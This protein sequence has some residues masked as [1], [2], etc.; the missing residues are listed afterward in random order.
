M[1]MLLV[2]G[3]AVF[4]GTVGA[5]IFRWL[6]IPQ[7]VGYI[8][9]GVAVGRTGLNIIDESLL[10][11]LDP[12]NFFA[13]GV[14]GFMIGGELRGDVFRKYGRQFL[15]ILVGE[16]IGAFVVVGLLVGGG[17]YLLRGDLN[18]AVAL[19]L[20]FGAISAATAPAAT[21][22]VLWEYKTR[23]P[24][25]RTVFAIV[26]MDD[27]LALVLYSVAASVAANLVGHGSGGFLTTIGRA[28]YELVG[29]AGLGVVAGLGLNLVLRRA[30][31]H[32]GV[33]AFIIGAVALV[34]GVGVLI[35]VD[36]ILASMALGMV[37]VNLAPRRSDRAFKIVERFAPPL[38]VL[39]FVIV[40]AHLHLQGMPGWMWVLAVPYVVG[41]TAGKIVGSN[42][43]GR[44]GKAGQPVCKYLGLCLFCQ[45][46][47]A[48]RL[49]IMA[50]KRFPGDMSDIGVAIIT[51]IA[52][53]TLVVE[54]LG[55]PCVKYAVK[56]AGEVGLN[57]TEEDLMQSYTV[58][59][60][61]DRSAPT[62]AESTS[63]AEIMR[64]IVETDATAYPVT[65]T[66]GG[67]TGVITF[68]ELKRSFGAE[69]LTLWLVAYDVMQPVPDRVTEDTP[70]VEAMTRMR[71]QDLEYLPVVVSGDDGERLVGMLE[72]RAVNRKVGQEI[73]RRRQQAGS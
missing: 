56:A 72:Q 43:G 44:L 14:I 48:V 25:T 38:Y 20:L 2:I 9:I 61:T 73:L 50:S 46:G 52:V 59:E 70:L 66:D 18:T 30:R 22:N 4:L 36:T 58:G 11:S 15:C 7:V 6:H 29:G 47:V 45:G 49:P 51:L 63:L 40:G 54:I 17:V 33:L 23:G 62:F 5:K 19:G 1:P 3:L 32:D 13:L 57:V 53:T 31:D 41:R 24:L 65:D 35:K 68:Q 67:L 64:T 16:G 26:A 69:G 39:F 55:P 34:V 60:M 10:E 42:L 28:G 21:V 27:A 71:E 12:F 37:L 8:A